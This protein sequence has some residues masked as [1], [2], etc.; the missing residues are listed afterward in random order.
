MQP[1]SRQD[2]ALRALLIDLDHC[3]KHAEQLPQTLDGFARVIAC[4]GGSEPK[5]PLGLVPLLASAIHDGRLE[6]IGMESA[7]KNAADFGLTFWAGRLVAEMPPNTSFFILSQ[8]AD[9]DHVVHMLQRID[10]Q[11][12]RLDGNTER[13]AALNVSA[14]PPKVTP[15]LAPIPTHEAVQAYHRQHLQRARSR[16][17]KKAALTN[18]IR[19]F[20][21]NRKQHVSPDTILQALMQRGIVAIDTQ[22]RV[23]YLDNTPAPAAVPTNETSPASAEVVERPPATPYGEGVI[24]F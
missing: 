18:S 12:E 7:D 19:A 13:L 16:P 22:G 4:Y 5:V 3:P 10:R 20:F 2:A 11:A 1:L 23:T 6:I 21:S 8:D 24:P 17:A 14:A 15:S 9:L